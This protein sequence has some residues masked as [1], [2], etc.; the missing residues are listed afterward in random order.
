MGIGH[1]KFPR[2][3][4]ILV[5][6][7]TFLV[8]LVSPAVFAGEGDG[9]GGGKSEPL[10]LVSSS[11]SSG[12][13]EAA[14]RPTIT[15]TFSKNV[16]NMSV[17][18]NNMG[19]FRLVSDSGSDVPINVIMGDDQINPG[20]RNDIIVKPNGD[21]QPGRTYVLIISSNLKA[22]SGAVMEQT[23]EIKFKTAGAATSTSTALKDIS[24]NSNESINNDQT[25]VPA[26][27][28]N[29]GQGQA[30]PE[31]QKSL[32]D[33]GGQ[34]PSSGENRGEGQTGDGQNSTTAASRGSNEQDNRVFIIGLIIVLAAA[35]IGYTTTKKGK[36]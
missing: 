18:D 31:S 15:M 24:T 27:G 2:Y 20:I 30:D 22:K 32:A 29:S 13:Q 8:L 25:A 23:A 3:R 12:Q 34:K 14:L 16:V 21:L 11:P 6:L 35:G 4:W 28:T 10:R 9:T 26:A 1:V 36:K 7:L 5:L 19:C 17:K 33:S